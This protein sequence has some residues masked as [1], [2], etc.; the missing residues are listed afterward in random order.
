VAAQHVEAR[1]SGLVVRAAEA[2]A[3]MALER[4]EAIPSSEGGV[5]DSV[6]GSAALG[7]SIPEGAPQPVSDAAFT[8]L[9]RRFYGQFSLDGVRAI[10]QLEE[11]LDNVVAHLTSAPDPSVSLTLEVNATSVGFDDRSQRVVK[12]NATQLGAISTEFE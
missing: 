2:V 12:E 5:H 7:G 10:R 4:S 8:T 3:Q 1:P 6:T 9:K 11:I